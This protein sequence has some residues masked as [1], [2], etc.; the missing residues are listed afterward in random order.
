MGIASITTGQFREFAGA[1]LRSLP[2]DIDPTT[3]QGW[4]DNQERLRKILRKALAPDNKPAGLPAEAS[5]Q[6]G[7][8]YPLSVDYGRDVK[9]GVR[10]G[11]Y[12]WTDSD[13][14]SHNFPTKQKGTAEIEVEFV[15]FNRYIST[16]EALRELDRMGYRPAELHELLAFGEKYPEVQREF[17]IVALGSV[18]KNRRG[19]RFVSSLCGSGST[20]SLEL[21]WFEN[22]WLVIYRFAAVRK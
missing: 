19:V 8:T 6:T 11:R 15:H 4:I 9:D 1:V 2:D 17:P 16:D 18:W 14:T 7:N 22:D 20:R 21:D 5:A 3:A 13:I 10:A 12:D